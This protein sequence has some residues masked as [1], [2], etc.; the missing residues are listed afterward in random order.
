MW[1]SNLGR[2]LYS[3][4]RSL[5]N[6]LHIIIPMYW[7]FSHIGNLRNVLFS[8]SKSLFSLSCQLIKMNPNVK[9]CTYCFFYLTHLVHDEYQVCSWNCT[10]H[11]RKKY[12][13]HTNFSTSLYAH[14]VFWHPPCTIILN[15]CTKVL[16]TLSFLD[17][18]VYMK[19]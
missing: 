18:Q 17:L 11:Y 10:V 12:D 1:Q 2:V 13:K 14:G 5:P 16:L 7:F 9:I 8:V 3:K 19:I 15:F 4:W 6:I